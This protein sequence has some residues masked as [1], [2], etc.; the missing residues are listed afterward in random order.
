MT[1]TAVRVGVARISRQMSTADLGPPATSMMTS[2]C[3]AALLKASSGLAV[4][5]TV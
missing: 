1:G 4:R 3:S 2:W 5:V